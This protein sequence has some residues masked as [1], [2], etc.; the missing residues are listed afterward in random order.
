MDQQTD[1]AKPLNEV[2]LS[3]NDSKMWRYETNESNGSWPCVCFPRKQGKSIVDK[4][5]TGTVKEEEQQIQQHTLDTHF[6][7]EMITAKVTEVM[8]HIS[9][10]IIHETVGK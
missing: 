3:F 7:A 6:H 1:T 10:S 8:Q 4:I 9:L 5:T 2:Y